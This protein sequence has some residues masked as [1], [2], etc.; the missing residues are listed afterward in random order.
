MSH[1]HDQE[2]EANLSYFLPDEWIKLQVF[3]LDTENLLSINDNNSKYYILKSRANYAPT[4]LSPNSYYFL[5]GTTGNHFHWNITD[6]INATTHYDVYLNASFFTHGSWIPNEFVTVNLDSVTTGNYTLRI[7]AFDGYGKYSSKNI[8]L[9]VNLAPEITCNLTSLSFTEGSLNHTISFT[10]NDT[11]NLNR[12]YNITK[13]GVEMFNG[14]WL[15]DALIVKNIDSLTSGLYTFIINAYDGLG[16]SDSY[17]FSVNVTDRP[18]ITSPP[19]YSYTQ[20][21]LGLS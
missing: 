13:N 10:T 15:S 5:N 19:D 6:A 8:T 1:T 18:F 14:T 11:L 16:G 4:I 21:T 9:I 17:S 12:F 7:V 20:Y 2:Y 3:A